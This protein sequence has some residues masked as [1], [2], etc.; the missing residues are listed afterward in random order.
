MAEER[1]Y[2]IFFKMKKVTISN[3]NLKIL[4]CNLCQVQERCS[5]G[6]TLVPM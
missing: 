2:F 6:V 3:R 5:G 4:R 1:K